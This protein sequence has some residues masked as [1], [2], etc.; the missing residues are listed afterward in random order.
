MDPITVGPEHIGHEHADFL[1]S[2]PQ[3]DWGPGIGVAGPQGRE[4]H[5]LG[6]CRLRWLKWG[7]GT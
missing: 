6:C 1:I 5:V 7:L 4:N 3:R 2:R